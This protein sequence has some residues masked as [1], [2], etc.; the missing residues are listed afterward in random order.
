MSNDQAQPSCT[1]PRKPQTFDTPHTQVPSELT[2]IELVLDLTGCNIFT[3][4]LRLN[5]FEKAT[6][7]RF[8]EWPLS[9][10]A[11]ISKCV[12]EWIA[13]NPQAVIKAITQGVGDNMCVLSIHWKPK[14]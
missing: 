3:V 2:R 7:H 6:G 12:E 4:P 9:V 10:Q 1:L 13:R 8:E 5:E 14:A 11:I